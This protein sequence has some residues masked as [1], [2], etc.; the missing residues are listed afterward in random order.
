[1]IQD[2]DVSWNRTIALY[3]E[4]EALLQSSNTVDC[5]P[6]DP[7]NCWSYGERA[8]LAKQIDH[9]KLLRDPGFQGML[10]ERLLAIS[11]TIDFGLNEFTQDM[12][13]LIDEIR[14]NLED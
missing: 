3:A 11:D 2:Q 13:L 1:V 9:T 4:H 10:T 8:A 14:A 6:G 12:K 7:A 5:K